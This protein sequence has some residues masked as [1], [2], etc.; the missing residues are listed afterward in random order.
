MARP[1]KLGE[2]IAITPGKV[3]FRNDV[4]ELIQYSPQVART[5]EIP[6]LIVPPWINKFYILDLNAEKIL[7]Q[8]RVSKMV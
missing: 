7:R 5:H 2:N 8:L 3:V 6:L 4:F 1:F